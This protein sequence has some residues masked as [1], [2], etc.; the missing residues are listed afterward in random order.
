MG[1]GTGLGECFLTPH[2][3]PMSAS[4]KP[5]CEED[6]ADGRSS[7]D[8]VSDKISYTCFSAEGGHVE[9]A[10]RNAL[11]IEL[12]QF[13]LKDHDRVSVERTVSGQGICNIYDFMVHK[14]PDQVNA[15]LHESIIADDQQKS[16]LIAQSA[17]TDVCCRQ[18]MEMFASIYG[19]EAGN[20]CLKY[21]PFGGLYLA[22]GITP[23]NIDIIA[24]ATSPFLTAF[25]NKGRVSD[26]L[27]SIPIYAVN[28]E[29]VGERGAQFVAFR[30]LIH[31]HGH[32]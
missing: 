23:K 25:H 26:F 3:I 10:P 20:V 4:T 9:F 30:D 2:H 31:L 18:A 29:D 11:E 1:A 7:K 24:G 13:L 6:M 16:A 8:S 5:T 21:M 12:L 32:Q 28:I 27:K 15:M 19:S 22:G 17:Q 14:F